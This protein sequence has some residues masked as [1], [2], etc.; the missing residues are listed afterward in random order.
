M[1]HILELSERDF[2]ITIINVIES[3]GKVDNMHE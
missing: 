2:K 1:A 3:V